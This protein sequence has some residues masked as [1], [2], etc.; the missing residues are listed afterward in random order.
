MIKWYG[1]IDFAIEKIVQVF[2][3]IFGFIFCGGK[4][5]VKKQSSCSLQL[6]NKTDKYVAFKVIFLFSHYNC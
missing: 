6:T 5:E 2:D 1:N 4:V 3:L